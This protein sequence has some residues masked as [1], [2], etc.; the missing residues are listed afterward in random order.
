[1]F[2]AGFGAPGQHG[3][4]RSPDAVPINIYP[5][6]VNEYPLIDAV[7]EFDILKILID[8]LDRYWT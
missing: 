7:K 3:Q 6:E 5:I 1:M 8:Y 2:A 4:K